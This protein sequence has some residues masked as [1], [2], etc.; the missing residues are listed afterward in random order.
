MTF[1]CGSNK[2]KVIGE[3][4]DV[5]S[6]SVSFDNLPEE[7]VVKGETLYFPNSFHVSLVYIQRIIERY[8]ITIPDFKNKILNDFCDFTKECDVDIVHYKDE[9]RFCTRDNIKKTVVVMCEISNLNK[10]FDFI[11]K[12]YG[13]KIEYPTTHVT[14]YNTLKG[15]PGIY[16]MDNDDIKN[17][18]VYI[19]NPLGKLL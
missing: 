2:Y 1:I 7:I 17:F 5:I 3:N 12:K 19:E 11:N 9:W 10:F 18:T 15:K 13:L 6:I 14:L 16:L 8:K 4:N